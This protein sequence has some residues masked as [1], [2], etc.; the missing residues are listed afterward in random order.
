[1]ILKA[2]QVSFNTEILIC[3]NHELQLKDTESAIKIKLIK[4]LTQLKGFKLVTT[5]LLV[6][7]KIESEDKTKYHNLYSRS[8]A[9]VIINESDIDYVFQSIYATIIR[10]SD[11]HPS[12]IT[13]AAKDFAKMLDF[14]DINFPV[15]IRDIHQIEKK[16]SIGI[17][18]FRYD[19]KEKYPIY[20]SK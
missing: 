4:L 14:K 1:M 17:S 20:V 3:S 6:F 10:S 9:K 18:D 12:R 15:N 8:K 13:K 11:H 7:K 5:L 2:S 16:N 19:N